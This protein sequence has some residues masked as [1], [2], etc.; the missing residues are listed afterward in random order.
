MQKI[1]LH[2]G[3]QK[4]L[5]KLPP[6]HERQIVE[7]IDALRNNPFAQDTKQLEGCVGLYRADVG[8]YRI[9]YYL[10]E[11]EEE[12]VLY[13]LIVGKRNDS[14]VYKRLKRKLR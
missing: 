2:R 7:R 13:V 3:V 4:F 1:V 6:K 12:P 11:F 9:V 10:E 5:R 8:E 14:D